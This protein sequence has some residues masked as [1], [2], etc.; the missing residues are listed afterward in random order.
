MPISAASIAQSCATSI[1]CESVFWLAERRKCRRPRS[2]STEASIG[3]KP[4]SR[5]A[6]RPRRRAC[7]TT[8]SE[9]VRTLSSMSPG[10]MRPS[11]TMR[12]SAMRAI[13]RRTGS[14]QETIANPGVSSMSSVAPVDCSKVRMLRPSRPIRRPFMSSLGSETEMAVASCVVEDV[15]RCIA[16]SSLRRASSSMSCST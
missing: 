4:R 15:R 10:E 3:G 6:S 2:S 11:F 16:E 9:A 5:T 1:E 8:S 12:S 7:F 13:S 14:K